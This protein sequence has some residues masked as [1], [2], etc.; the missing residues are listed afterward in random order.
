MTFKDLFVLLVDHVG[1][2]A[3]RLDK[4][5]HEIYP[6][7]WELWPME[8]EEYTV[9]YRSPDNDA[10]KIRVALM[11]GE[12][13]EELPIPELR[14]NDVPNWRDEAERETLQRLFAYFPPQ[15]VH[16]NNNNRRV[17]PCVTYRGGVK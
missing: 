5:P 16:L 13:M 12:T 17:S 8:G 3:D 4:Q 2:I 9:F 15:S 6:K 11:P 7:I 10:K 14:Y 1:R